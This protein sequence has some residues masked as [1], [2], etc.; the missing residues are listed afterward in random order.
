MLSKQIISQNGKPAFVVLDYDDY[1][2]YE[3]NLEDKIDSMLIKK[4]R[5][6]NT[7]KKGYSS[8]EAKKLMGL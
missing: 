8:D 3:T 4:L 2:K 1:M 5:E 6:R 7:G